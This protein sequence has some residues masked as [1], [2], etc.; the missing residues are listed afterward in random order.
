VDAEASSVRE[1]AEKVGLDWVQL[2]GRESPQYCRALGRRVV[3]GFRIRD[4]NSL[5]ALPAYRGAVQAFL[6]DTYKPGTP[7]GTGESFD[8]DLARP[9]GEYGPIILAGG[10][11]AGNVAA[12]IRAAQPQAVD[13]GSGVEAV[14]GK[15][16]PEK[17]RSFFEAI[18]LVGGEG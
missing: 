1:I 12:A 8:W 4:E 6:L 10:L 5:A 13:V 18:K 9:A 11:N 14:P 3:K 2:H 7:G 16:D 17:L 15:K